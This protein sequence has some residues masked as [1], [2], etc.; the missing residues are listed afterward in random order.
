MTN[1]AD[2][3]PIIE[4]FTVFGLSENNIINQEIKSI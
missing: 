4:N 1:V 3:V 2:S